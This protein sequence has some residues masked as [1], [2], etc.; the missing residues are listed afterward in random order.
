MGKEGLPP[1]QDIIS[2]SV[3]IQM[4]TLNP[5]TEG[6]AT[7][8]TSVVMDNGQRIFLLEGNA[9]GNFNVRYYVSES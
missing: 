1:Y 8:T 3:K 4:N 7:L 6:T 5:S 9:R 2:A